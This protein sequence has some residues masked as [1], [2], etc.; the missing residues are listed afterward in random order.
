MPKQGKDPRIR[1]WIS[2]Q[3]KFANDLRIIGER[4]KCRLETKDEELDK[5]KK[6][7]LE[8]NDEELDK[9]K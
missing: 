7:R 8:T 1:L 6:C 9:E 3:H 4:R 5:E 2:G